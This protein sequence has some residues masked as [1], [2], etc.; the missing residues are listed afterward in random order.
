MRDNMHR[1]QV[2]RAISPI[3]IADNT[4][5]VGQIID[6][7]GADSLTYII[8][9]GTLA[10]ADATFAVLLQE[11]DQSN[12]G[13]ASTVNDV[14]MISGVR[15]TAPLTAAGFIFSSDDMVFRLGYIGNR[16]YTRLT[17][18]PANNTGSAPVSAVAVRGNLRF[19][20]S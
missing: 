19:Q 16:R 14:D 11:G 10:D 4:P 6:N 17:I 18:T 20:P 12:L 7:Q 3:T 1:M 2:L 15:G 8:N 13:D 9:T 5:A